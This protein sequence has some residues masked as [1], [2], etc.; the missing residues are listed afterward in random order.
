MRVYQAVFPTSVFEN[1]TNTAN[2]LYGFL[3]G[4]TVSEPDILIDD[5]GITS[6]KPPLAPLI[7][8]LQGMVFWA[9]DGQTLSGGLAKAAKKAFPKDDWDLRSASFEISACGLTWDLGSEMLQSKGLIALKTIG[10]NIG[11]IFNPRTG[12]RQEVRDVETAFGPGKQK[13]EITKRVMDFQSVIRNMR[14]ASHTNVLVQRGCAVLVVQTQRVKRGVE[15][16]KSFKFSDQYG[17]W[18]KDFRQMG[19]TLSMSTLASLVPS[20][21]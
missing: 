10:Y 12:Y 8:G 1:S 13:V 5:H 15:N 7:T 18:G 20:V 19:K 2:S 9:K 16:G 17:N 11:Q 21:M 3:C 4:H 14:K 6:T